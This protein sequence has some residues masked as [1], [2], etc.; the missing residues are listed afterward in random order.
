MSDSNMG[1]RMG[2]LPAFIR[3]DF[4]RKFIALFFALIVFYKVSKQIGIEETVDN[5]KLN[6]FPLGNLVVL[7]DETVS[8]KITV[9][10]QDQKTLLSI[11]PADFKFNL[12]IPEDKSFEL[13]KTRTFKIL[14]SARIIKPLGIEILNVRPETITLNM[15]TKASREL[16][17][18]AR[19]TGATQDDYTCG[20][21]FVSPEKVLVT[22]PKSFLDKLNEVYTESVIL[23][24][25]TIEDFECEAKIAAPLKM[26]C[27]PEKIQVQV[28]VYKKIDIRKFSGIPLE[29]LAPA[30]SKYRVVKISPTNVDVTV[31]GLK[32]VIERTSQKELKPFIDLSKIEKAGVSTIKPSCFINAQGL[33][34]VEY[35]PEEISVEITEGR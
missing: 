10:A 34:A 24:E 15:D 1:R 7:G 12:E 20:E 23:D 30:N 31:Q 17:V 28:E 8:L 11:T 18:K 14:E 32:N 19:F 4:I 3:H 25:R 21:V 29:V 16:P 27:S 2:F 33:K 6:L 13:Q 5:V 26:I 35:V 22:G 9:K